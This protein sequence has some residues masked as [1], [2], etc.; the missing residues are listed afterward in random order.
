MRYAENMGR[1]SGQSL[2]SG[3]M[4]ALS[5]PRAFRAVFDDGRKYH[6]GRLGLWV[7]HGAERRVGLVVSGKFGTAVARNRMRRLLREALRLRADRLPSGEIVLVP[8]QALRNEAD[9]EGL[10]AVVRAL[11]RVLKLQRDQHR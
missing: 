2:S 6:D 10:V 9:R 1:G 11:D 7:R 3:R 4:Q 8:T 5:G